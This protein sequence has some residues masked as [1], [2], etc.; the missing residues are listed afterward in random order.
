[1]YMQVLYD[2]DEAD[3]GVFMRRVEAAVEEE[4]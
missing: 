2:E 4:E 1:M 3:S